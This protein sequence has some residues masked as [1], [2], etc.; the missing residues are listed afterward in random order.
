MAI[1]TAV[2]RWAYAKLMPLGLILLA[3]GLAPLAQAGPGAD[4]LQ[5]IITGRIRAH[6]GEQLQI[7]YYDPGR[8][9]HVLLAQDSLPPGRTKFRLTFALSKPRYLS[10]QRLHTARELFLQPGDSLHVTIRRRPDT[11][12]VFRY[13]GERSRAN[14]DLHHF[15]RWFGRI[16]QNRKGLRLDRMKYLR[17]ML[18]WT[19][20]NV[21]KMDTLRPGWQSAGTPFAGALAAK[22]YYTN[23]NKL[24]TFAPS[25]R[26][27]RGDDTLTDAQFLARLL[28]SVRHYV[29]PFRP[30]L[31]Q[32]TGYRNFLSR[33][34]DRLQ[35]L[36]HARHGQPERPD[37]AAACALATYRQFAAHADSVVPFAQG[38]QYMRV[39][40]LVLERRHLRYEQL[41][42]ILRD[43]EQ[44]FPAS[45]YQPRLQKWLAA[46]QGLQRGQPA[47]AFA[48]QDSAGQVRRL[49]DYR[50]RWVL[51]DF[52]ASWC[53]GCV[54]D[55]PALRKLHRR[56]DSLPAPLQ[57]VSISLDP[58]R[59][60]WRQALSEYELPGVQLYAPGAYDNET[61][62]AYGG[63]GVP[64]YFL[65]DPK[66]RLV[67]KGPKPPGQGA[68][69]QIAELMR[70]WEGPR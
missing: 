52:W 33:Y 54:Q 45:P 26:I 3:P 16:S 24:L 2:L 58:T 47:P 10:T 70:N 34:V 55:A 12:D 35:E 6:D 29:A 32:Y 11:L 62:Q 25:S 19:R 18:K 50:G 42:H 68:Y 59:N 22:H 49:A 61:V 44:Q 1:Q 15:R 39:W 36:A 14:Q 8:G 31:M 9:E 21:R 64:A 41:A 69:Q 20:Q 53:P 27:P 28:D 65:I 37:S 23:L 66:G 63:T 67:R 51:L 40:K 57:M 56:K 43:F 7:Q 38:R 46:A 4:P 48:L 30:A 60:Q 5:T 13:S 17:L